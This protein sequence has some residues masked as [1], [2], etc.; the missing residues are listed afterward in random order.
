VR[1]AVVTHDQRCESISKG[2]YAG[3]GLGVRALIRPDNIE[4]GVDAWNCEAVEGGVAE[5]KRSEVVGVWELVPSVS[6]GASLTMAD[7]CCF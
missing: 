3:P 6:L 5:S 1:E 2:I 4:A 7:A